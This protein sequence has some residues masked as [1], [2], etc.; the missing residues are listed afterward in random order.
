MTNDTH[1]LFRDNLPAYALGALDPDETAS[2][3]AHL[4]TCASCQ[5][6]L[7]GYRLVSESLLTAIPPKHPPA[8]LRRRLQRHLPTRKKTAAMWRLWP[9]GRAIVTLLVL[10]LLGLN[11]FT[12]NQLQKIQQ[13]Q[14]QLLAQLE[15]THLMLA[16]LSSP[17]SQTIPVQSEK[18][19]GNLLLD[20]KHNKAILIVQDL[21]PLPETQ[22]YQIWLI[23]PDGKRISAGLFRPTSDELY[24][25]QMIVPSQP[26]TSFIGLGV[27]IE[28]AGGSEAPTG[29]RIFK[30]DF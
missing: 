14:T 21:P 9:S 25:A 28:P 26:F 11:L 2:L 1:A 23:Q 6:E 18:I 30:V 5:T 22:S 17:N 4:Q 15:N 10:L 12:L 8:A 24:T 20:K 19:S 13:Q 16:M 7:A 27:T 3:E 29:Q